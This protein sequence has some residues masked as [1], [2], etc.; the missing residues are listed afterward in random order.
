VILKSDKKWIFISDGSWDDMDN[1]A[2]AAINLDFVSLNSYGSSLYYDSV[3]GIDESSKYKVSPH[4][5][6]LKMN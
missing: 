2:E 1:V 6:R 4:F 3:A 5:S